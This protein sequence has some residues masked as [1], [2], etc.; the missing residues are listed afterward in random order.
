M[1]GDN[2]N[3]PMVGAI[4]KN[5]GAVYIPRSFGTDHR[6]VLYKAVFNAYIAEILKSGNSL[7]VFLEGLLI[8]F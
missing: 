8:T 1:I 6:A 4:L 7:E 2:L 5:N 3:F